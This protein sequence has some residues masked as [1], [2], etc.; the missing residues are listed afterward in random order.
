MIEYSS[1]RRGTA[2]RV[3][4]QAP[5]DDVLSSCEASVTCI[6][7]GVFFV[8]SF[9]GKSASYTLQYFR[10]PEARLISLFPNEGPQQGGGA[11][12]LEAVDYIGPETRHGGGLPSIESAL[13]N[14]SLASIRFNP[15]GA[16]ASNVTLQVSQT[17]A[18]DSRRQRRYTVSGIAPPGAAEGIYEVQLVYNGS[19]IVLQSSEAGAGRYQYVGRKPKLMWL[20]PRGGSVNPGSGG[21]A[22]SAYI[23]NMPATP[24]SSINVSLGGIACRVISQSNSSIPVGTQT[25]IAF[26]SPEL[27]LEMAGLPNVTV[28][29]VFPVPGGGGE[30]GNVTAPWD[31]VAPRKPYVEKS[32]VI[33]N[34]TSTLDIP[35][36]T[37]GIPVSLMV[38]NMHPSLGVAHFDLLR[39]WFGEF[40][41]LFIDAR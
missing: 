20:S 2:V 39:L 33:V 15:G 35:A 26:A 25:V 5:P 40:G 16:L 1:V 38:H 37:D 36:L 32:S 13:L 7:Q 3:T 30:L 31:Y 10:Y 4:P 19:Q 11:F 29:V 14:P 18:D 27:P 8:P 23:A 6:A 28:S 21:L 24:L 12:R 34:G 22:I 17:P 41:D 9:P